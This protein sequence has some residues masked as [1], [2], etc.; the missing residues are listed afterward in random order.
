MHHR[1]P[2]PRLTHVATAI[3]A[4]LAASTPTLATAQSAPAP[5]TEAPAAAART[6]A[7]PTLPT[8]QVVGRR[9]SGAYHDGQ[10]AGATKTDTPL[11][12]VPQAVRV[13]PRQ[14]LDDLGALRLDDT[15]DFVAGVS[16]QN[17][18]GGTWDNV[19]IR[20]FQGH[21]DTTMSLLRNGMPSN[22]GF[23][24]PRDT[25]NLERI[26]FLKGTLGALYGASEPGGSVNLVT[27]QPRFTAG[28]S[29]EAYFGSFGTKRLALDSTGPLNGGSAANVSGNE[30]T[31]QAYRLNLSVEDKDGFRDHTHSRRE[32]LAPALTWKLSPDTQLRYDGEVLR[33]RAPLDRGVPVINGQLGAV[34]STR[35]YGEPGDGDITIVNQTHQLFVDHALGADWLL[36]GGLQLK[37]GTL[38][39]RATEP[40]QYGPGALGCSTSMNTQDWLCRRVRWRDYSSDETSLQLEATGKLRTGASSTRCW[41]APRPRASGR[42]ARCWTTRAVSVTPWASRCPTRNTAR[43]RRRPW[44]PCSRHGTAS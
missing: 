27:K 20:G 25:A 32:L 40:H 19:A 12:E 38:E 17:N 18:F 13:L 31:T 29:V 7:E 33:Q 41:W 15:L 21:E 4:W 26:E 11:L 3:A 10:S 39:G 34:P 23:N 36:R 1:F 6:S 44:A 2:R 5:S 30:P 14:L 28:H 16:R 42:T 43:C 22:R 8:V 24:A 37:R 35:F 9:Q